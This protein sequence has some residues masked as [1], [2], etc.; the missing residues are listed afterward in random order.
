MRLLTD[1]DA[2]AV[3]RRL[4]PLQGPVRLEYF[5]ESASGL[6]IPGRECRSCLDTQRLLEDL[7]ACSPLLSLRIHDR[8]G[9]PEAFAAYGIDKVPGI[10]PV[11]REDYGIRYYGMPGGY[12]F[13]TFLDVI[14]DVASGTP[15]LAPQTRDALI[16]LPAPVHIQVFV[17]PT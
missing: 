10:A 15:E 12:E 2:E 9:D 5:T 16:T 7:V 13:A 1:G 6:I 14:L 17:T 11:G 4:E 3:R 8:V